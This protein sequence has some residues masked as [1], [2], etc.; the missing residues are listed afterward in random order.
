[1]EIRKAHAFLRQLVEVGRV[2]L[3]A[4]CADITEAPIV[5]QHDHHVRALGQSACAD[6]AH[7]GR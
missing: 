5:R 2:H 6:D 3:A 7:Q 4:K 1:M